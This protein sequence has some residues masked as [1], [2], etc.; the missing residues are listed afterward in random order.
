MLKIKYF[1]TF[2]S[3]AFKRKGNQFYSSSEATMPPC[4]YEV[5]WHPKII[6]I[7]WEGSGP[8]S[9]LNDG[10]EGEIMGY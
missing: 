2:L 6:T 3:P 7:H 8:D 1:L 10:A 9:S 5:T 4:G